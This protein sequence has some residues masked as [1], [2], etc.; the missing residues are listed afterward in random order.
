M[1]FLLASKKFGYIVFASTRLLSVVFAAL[2]PPT[3]AK[4]LYSPFVAN[5]LEN[6][7]V[8]PWSSWLS[9]QGGTSSPD[10]FPYGWSILI[11]MSIGHLVFGTFWSPII[12][13]LFLYLVA[14]IAVLMSLRK[15][16]SAR[17]LPPTTLYSFFP[18]PPILL[19]LIGPNDFFPM[20]LLAIGVLAIFRN[21]FLFGS[22]LFGL[23]VGMKVL[24]IF[25]LVAAL[26]FVFRQEGYRV[27][28]FQMSLIA[29]VAMGA[30]LSP[31][32]YSRGFRE[33]L[34]SSEIAIA[35]LTV[36]A[37]T[38]GGRVLLA[39]VLVGLA[40]VL[41][42]RIKRMNFDLLTL[43]IVSPLLALGS[44]PGSPLGWQLWSLPLLSLLLASLAP[45]YYLLAIF[46]S[47]LQVYI[48]FSGM[49]L[50]ADSEGLQIAWRDI[51]LSLGI[52]T[53]VVL[54]SMLWR[55]FFVRS[56]FIKLRKSPALVL[57]AGDSSTGKDTL[58]SGLARCLGEGL[59]VHVSGD[60]FHRWGRKN[61]NWNFLTHLNPE[62]NDLDGYFKAISG[63]MSGESA[64]LPRY[65]H[66]TGRLHAATE[67]SGREF[68]ISSGLHALWSVDVNSVSSL[69][70]FLS[71]SDDLRL[72]LKLARDTNSRGHSR[73]SVVASFQAR[74]EDYA[75]HLLPQKDRADLG[76][77]SEFANQRCPRVDQIAVTFRSS[78]KIFDS[79]LKAELSHTC[80][81]EIEHYSLAD[82]K[83][84]IR[85]SGVAD[86][87][88]LDTAFSRIEPQMSEVIFPHRH[89]NAGAPGIVQFVS[90]V[91]LAESLRR[92]RLIR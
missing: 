21:Y 83:R 72:E 14:D 62:A 54:L 23:A 90:L 46:A 56:D 88:L 85:V 39:P 86:P 16:N 55:E 69:A 9:T 68:V 22:L 31:L 47:T 57:I 76:I 10:A 12:G 80:G 8:D 52:F 1:T 87:S 42:W 49:N 71:M 34:S 43:T 84:D 11:L 64:K 75:T 41:L 26:I 36:G 60:D 79:K 24:L 61:A 32:L 50:P 44:L 35:A 59:T 28:A 91:Y 30:S 33:A 27:R 7:S 89:W 40:I 77:H 78:P 29:S 48:F 5:F 63:L 20:A 2:S 15:F 45:R 92:D 38:P 4:D 6:P 13:V 17:Q 18:V 19:A 58:A 65:D 66:D 70:I 53:N 25:A 74:K 81:L 3:L 73:A 82:G 67:T 37:D 51:A